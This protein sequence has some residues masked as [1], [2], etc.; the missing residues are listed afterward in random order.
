MTRQLIARLLVAGTLLYGLSYGLSGIGPSTVLGHAATNKGTDSP[1]TQFAAR[2][3][4][5]YGVFRHWVAIPYQRGYFAPD[6]PDR[7]VRLD[8]AATALLSTES[9]LGAA[10]TIARADGGLR[11]I[12]PLVAG[13]ANGYQ[14]LAATFRSGTVS[15]IGM[16]GTIGLTLYTEGV[17]Q[18]LGIPVR[19]TNPVPGSR[20]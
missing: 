4:V 13:M 5:A 11:P 2:M 20:F 8:K 17:Q 6:K 3:G 16:R 10:L 7:G 12:V 19:E 9:D 15:P 1:A 18:K 14:A